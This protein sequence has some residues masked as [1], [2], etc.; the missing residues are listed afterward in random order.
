MELFSD[1]KT[2][3]PAA[4][5]APA[6]KKSAPAAQESMLAHTLLRRPRVTEKSYTLG[7]LSQYVFEVSPRANKKSI[8]QAVAEAYGVSVVSVNIIRIPGK[9]KAFGAAQIQGKRRDLKK[10]IVTLTKGQTIETFNAG[11]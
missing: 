5:K 9:R 11:L 4:K 3:K 2:K 7:A 1:K 8:A 6:K 10:A